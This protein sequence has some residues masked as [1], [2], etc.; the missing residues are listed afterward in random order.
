MAQL[1]RGVEESPSLGLSK[2]RGDVGTWSVGTVRWVGLENLTGLSNLNDSMILCPT[3]NRLYLYGN[4]WRGTYAVFR[5][6]SIHAVAGL[7]H[8]LRANNFPKM[9]LNSPLGTKV[10]L[11]PPVVIAEKTASAETWP[12]FCM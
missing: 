2:N 11:C 6:D 9:Q 8:K 3:A 4:V 5:A 1:P 12:T 10:R 7:Q